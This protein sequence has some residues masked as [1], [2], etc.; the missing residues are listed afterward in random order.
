MSTPCRYGIPATILA[1]ALTGN[2]L[3]SGSTSAVSAEKPSAAQSQAAQATSQ[4]MVAASAPE[5]AATVVHV[6]V[7][8]LSN[9]HP[10]SPYVYGGAY[11][12]DAGTVSDSGITVVRWGGN[13]T[14]RYNWKAGTYNAANDWYYADF[15]YTEIGDADSAKFIQDVKA[16]GSNPLMT[17]V[18]LDWVAKNVSDGSAYSFGIAK[19][20]AQCGI[21]PYNSDDGN[22]LKPDCTTPITGNDPNDANFPLK[23]APQNGDPVSTLYRNQWTAAL[24]AAF[25]SAPHFYDMD[26]E[27][28]IWSGTHRDVHPQPAAYNEMRD[29]FIAESRA[30]K[31]WDPAAIRLGPVSCC[32]WF[33]WN[34]ANNDDKAAHA[35]NDL[36]PWWLNEVY[37]QDKIAGA[38]SVDLFD[39]HAYPDTPDTSGFTLARKRALATRIYRDYWDPKYVSESGSINQPWAT[40]IQPNKTIPFRIPRMRALAN[41]IYPGTPLA[42]TEWS[43]EIAGGSD[44]STALGDADAYGIL[45]RERVYLASRW[46]APDPANPNYQ[47]IKLYRNYDGQ[48]HG[49]ATTS[50]SASNDAAPNLFSSYAAVDPT[51]KTLTLMM[52]NKKPGGAVTVQVALNGFNP[53]QVTSYTLSKKNPAI[54]VASGPQA[55][56]L[57]LSL[58]PYS[59]TLF[60]IAGSMPQI[61]AAEWDLNPDTIMVPANGR[62]ALAPKIVSGSGTVTLGAPQADAGIALAVTQGAVTS[63]QNGAITVTGGSKAGFYHFTVP[64]T[65]NSGVAQQQSGWILVGNPAATFSKTGDNQSGTHG[66]TLNL[67][68]TLQ[69]GQS[70][71]TASGATVF[72]TTDAGTL[73]NRLVTTDFSG[74]AAVTLTL[75]GTAATVHVIAEGPF[76]LG[77]PIATFTETSQ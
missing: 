23:D 67:S 60:V 77:H 45:G 72:F 14:S 61:P 40:Q 5:P 41:T 7:D 66:T 29:K 31:T 1:L 55:W 73:S 18:M 37:W 56:T 20:G 49:F 57:S 30:L 32:W 13:A 22:G 53:S 65:D 3:G 9:R 26:N 28:D 43:A 11:P 8:A 71:G 25:G 68:V 35:G 12:K 4:Q 17:M 59:A 64:G 47:A 75:P 34:G 48:H 63:T 16:A 24:A 38:R 44:F 74:K 2:L 21:N 52:I 70:G 33:Y 54:I 58:P 10:I 62:V 39:I 27:I 15:G 51:G 50:V 76:G 42:M 46:V 19:Y 69:P 6:T 36:L